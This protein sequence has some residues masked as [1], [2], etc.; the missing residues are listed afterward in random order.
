ML[1][2]EI[3]SP[4]DKTLSIEADEITSITIQRWTNTIVFLYFY[5]NRG[6]KKEDPLLNIRYTTTIIDDNPTYGRTQQLQ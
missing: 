6:L 4:V 2:P 3:T 1:N 5:L